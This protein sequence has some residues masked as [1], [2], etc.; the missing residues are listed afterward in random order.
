MTTTDTEAPAVM[1]VAEHE[2]AMAEF[3]ARVRAEAM[4]MATQHNLCATVEQTLAKVGISNEFSLVTI[5][6]TVTEETVFRVPIDLLNGYS[7]DDLKKVIKKRETTGLS[8]KEHRSWQQVQQITNR[9]LPG[10]VTN[11]T[12]ADP[13]VGGYVTAYSSDQGRV[14]HLVRETIPGSALMPGRRQRNEGMDNVSLCGAERG[15]N[16]WYQ[17]S[18]RGEGRMCEKCTRRQA[19]L[20]S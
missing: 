1:T 13:S 2:K 9:R 11:V 14:L 16:G 19:A 8:G 6:K 7:E 3:K 12:I 10:E 5:T 15:W 4:D 18:Q 17:N 20:P